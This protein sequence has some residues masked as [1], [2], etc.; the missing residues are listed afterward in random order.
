MA[1]M[2]RKLAVAASTFGV[3][4]AVCGTGGASSAAAAKSS[5][6]LTTVTVTLPVPAVSFLP[7]YIGQYD[8]LYKK[9]GLKVLLQYVPPAVETGELLATKVQFLG[10]V[11]VGEQ[12]A[13]AK[14]PSQFP[15]KIVEVSTQYSVF[16][17]V[18]APGITSLNQLVGKVVAGDGAAGQV[19][20]VLQ[21]VLG[22]HGIQ[23]SQYSIANVANE[24]AAT[25]LVEAGKASATAIDVVELASPALHGFK[26]LATGK[27]VLSLGSGLV[28]TEARIST[29]ASLVR[30]MVSVTARAT[31]LAATNEKV[32]IAALRR[33]MASLNLGY[34]TAQWK[35]AWKDSRYMFTTNGKPMP[36]A[37][38]TFLDLIQKSTG[39]PSAPP[40]SL[41]FDFKFLGKHG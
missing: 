1:V 26:I 41:L 40:A 14:S 37:Q 3:L 38:Q 15:L 7:Y 17:V 10:A 25:A 27:S 11:S 9:A 39:L 22:A 19:T 5:T 31:K 13:I 23:P 4:V 8:G 24:T 2:R 16:D 18:G 28:T 29:Q 12:N 36:A 30:R 34:S 32:A 20:E 21:Q 33:G 6:Q 35:A